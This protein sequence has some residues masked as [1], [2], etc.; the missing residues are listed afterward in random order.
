VNLSDKDLDLIYSRLT[1]LFTPA[2]L[3]ASGWLDRQPDRE[4]RRQL[5][6]LDLEFFVRFYLPA[7]FTK[8]M[9][10]LHQDLLEEVRSSIAVQG[11]TNSV[12]ALPRGF[13]KTT[14]VTLGV[15]A[16]AV[17]NE[18]RKYIIIVSDASEQSD[19]QLE[20]LKKE[21]EEN[22]RIL[23][24][25]G[26][27]KGEVWAVGHI[28]TT[29]GVTIES[30]GAGK[31]IRGR[32]FRQ[33][34]PDLIIFD[35]IENEEEAASPK[36]REARKRWYYGAAQRAGWEDTKTLTIGNLLHSECLL[37]ELLQNPM[38]R[39]RRHQAIPSWPTRMDLWDQWERVLTD[40]TRETEAALD[41]AWE[42][43]SAHRAEMDLNAT[44]SWPEAFPFYELMRI[45]AADGHTTFAVEMQNDP[46]DPTSALFR[47]FERYHMEA[48]ND[49][50]WLVP[51]TG[52]PEV[53]LS[54]CAI[55]AFTDP[56]MGQ[57]QRS[58]YSAIIIIAK[59]FYGLMFILV[60][61][62]QVRSPD[63]IMKAQ[64]VW[65]RQHHL[66]RWGMESNQFQALFASES[67]LRALQ[68][69]VHIPILQVPQTSNK[70]LRIQS[71]EPD[72]NNGWIL[73]PNYGAELLI[74][75]LRNF[76][77]SDHDDGPDALEG[78]RNL[79]VAWTGLPNTQV[80][81]SEP[82]A[83]G[84]EIS[85]SLRSLQRDP[86]ASYEDRIA[87]ALRDRAVELEDLA[88]ETLDLKERALLLSEL[89]GVMR[90][91]ESEE[92]QVYVPM[93]VG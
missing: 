39:R 51:H 30:L 43:Y 83:F 19:A 12:V 13:G 4:F 28:I 44:S 89:R 11:R 78:A 75:Q 74:E 9:A 92:A 29:N 69:G 22:P 85:N 81:T 23:E 58:D 38:Y 61:D 62:I 54:N 48:R 73:F 63:A 93:I 86:Y 24:D 26:E 49:E 66:T 91:I 8:P 84:T 25:F 50:V 17:C 88:K 53:K 87:E 52:Q 6:S 67:G 27:L 32:K 15:P 36:Q 42:F 37:A 65:A 1:L 76:G 77:S 14:I 71:L 41:A 56:S 60:A 10:P 18:L 70:I 68:E 80:I 31:K 82:F 20:N 16:W 40:R 45:R 7:H 57:G 90:E 5:S 33:N 34:R 35:D 55:F 47:R 21:F 64:I 79:A 46:A 59:A 3:E 72:I 2:E